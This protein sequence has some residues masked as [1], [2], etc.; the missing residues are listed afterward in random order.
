M[1]RKHVP[2]R[3]CIACG[4]VRSK[5][6]LMRIVRTPGGR[7]QVD[8]TGKHPGRGAYLCQQRA[9]WERGLARGQLERALKVPLSP[10]DRAELEAY[11]QG[12]PPAGEDS[13]GNL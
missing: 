12:I 6:E 7:V 1:R 2:Q 9:C 5:R 10:E 3:R 11:G 8:P 4:Q 13:T